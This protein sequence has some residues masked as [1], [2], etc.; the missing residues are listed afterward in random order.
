VAAHGRQL[1][2]TRRQSTAGDDAICRQ[3]VHCLKE[4]LAHSLHNVCAISP[5]ST[6]AKL[7]QH[8]LI[9]S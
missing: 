6:V 8:Q 3:C 9:S 2:Q 1:L 7:V 5:V 4:K